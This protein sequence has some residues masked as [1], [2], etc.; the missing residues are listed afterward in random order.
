VF[1]LACALSL[2]VNG[3]VAPVNID[4]LLVV[5]GVTSPLTETITFEYPSK[6]SSSASYTP[7][8]VIVFSA[9]TIG[10]SAFAIHTAYKSTD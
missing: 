4:W 7:F 10:K 1:S 2:Y 5:G 9:T 6:L 3:I 8:A